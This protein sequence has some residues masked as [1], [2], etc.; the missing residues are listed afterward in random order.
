MDEAGAK[1]KFGELLFDVARVR[2][3]PSLKVSVSVSVK[4][5]KLP[6]N[7]IATPVLR[8]WFLVI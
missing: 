5:S 1:R 8:L 6:A 3:G 7:V 2:L 4:F